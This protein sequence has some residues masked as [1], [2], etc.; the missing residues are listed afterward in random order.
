MDQTEEK[1]EQLIASAKAAILVVESSQNHS[2]E[3]RL[4]IVLSL[5]YDLWVHE[6]LLYQYR[7]KKLEEGNG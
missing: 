4:D 7:L 1:L 6:E 3:E 2:P 5:E